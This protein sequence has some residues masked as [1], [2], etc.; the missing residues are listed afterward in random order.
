MQLRIQVV[1]SSATPL[2]RQVVD[3][4]RA[5]VARGELQAG[6][7]LPS[8]RALAEEL[9]INMNTVAKAY[10]EL[11]RHGDVVSEPG[12]GVFAS[13][14]PPTTSAAERRRRLAVAIERLIAEAV[15]LGVGRD[16]LVD[17]IVT[18]CDRAGLLG[19]SAREADPKPRTEKRHG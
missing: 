11:V 10:T 18:Y 14:A 6:D 5:A 7:P 9:R 8:V 4:V 16:E 15:H 3:Q 17:A 2:Y 13:A 1:T 19:P 12:R